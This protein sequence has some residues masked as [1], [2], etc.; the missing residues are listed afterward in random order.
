MASERDVES[1]RQGV[2]EKYAAVAKD[3]TGR[4]AYT[5][6]RAGAELLAYDPDHLAAAAE[7]LFDA[8]CG[9][10]NPFTVGEIRPGERVLDVGCGAGL[11]LFVAARLV[12]PE[13]RACGIDLTPE[14]A[15]RA[16]ANLAAVGI[17][18]AE[19]RVAAA[20][21]IPYP[22]HTFD[23]VT[24][25]G[26]LNLSPRKDAAFREIHRVLSPGGRLHLAD[27]CLADG[28]PAVESCSI[29]AWSQ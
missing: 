26:V 3:V 14:M 21:A 8:Y 13:G 4:F 29:D 16:R 7:P 1:I 23:V 2:R 6:G 9:V 27:I 17:G 12:G 19:V 20:E 5:T 11:D 15:A 18:H 28:V 10:G 25:N 22:D 24:S